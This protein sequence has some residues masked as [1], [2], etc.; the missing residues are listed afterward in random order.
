MRW[1]TQLGAGPYKERLATSLPGCINAKREVVFTQS[2]LLNSLVIAIAIAQGVGLLVAAVDF[3]QAVGWEALLILGR[4]TVP[5]LTV[6]L[7]FSALALIVKGRSA[8]TQAMRAADEGRINLLIHFFDLLLIAPP[9]GLLLA[10]MGLFF[11]HFGL[12][13]LEQDQWSGVALPIVALVAVFVGDFIGYWRHR[14]EHTRFLWPSHA[15]HH[16]DTEMT[17]TALF[18]FHPVNRLTTAVL[19]NAVLMALGLPPEALLVNVTVRHYYGFFIHAD[20]PWTYGP[21]KYVLV[22]PAM[23]RW[24]HARDPVY[25][26]TNFATVFSIF[27]LAFGTFRVPGPCNVPLGIDSEIDKS[28]VGQLSY[29]LR[30]SAYRQ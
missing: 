11:D 17:W 1:I 5:L 30:P 24:H 3:V 4:S 23:H 29:P 19:D 28:V 18:R 21:L 14:L 2:G 7:F 25:Y 27:D 9:L 26:K 6:A 12:R 10:S 22:S 8:L 15:I 20:L 16:S 13:I